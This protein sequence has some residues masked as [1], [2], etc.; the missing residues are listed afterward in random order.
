MVAVEPESTFTGRVTRISR[1][2]AVVLGLLSVGNLV[3]W[4]NRW[5]ITERFAPSLGSED[6]DF[7]VWMYERMAVVHETLLT[8][9]VLGLAGAALA[10]LGAR[11]DARARRRA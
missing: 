9:V 8:A 3:A 10:V 1:V 7:A 2:L 6:G 5:Y 4:A 11:L